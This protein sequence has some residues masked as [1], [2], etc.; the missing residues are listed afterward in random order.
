MPTPSQIMVASEKGKLE[1]LILNNPLLKKSIPTL[2]NKIGMTPFMYA[3]HK[4]EGLKAFPEEFITQEAFN[5]SKNGGETPLHFLA[6]NQ[7]QNIKDKWCTSENVTKVNSSNETPAH[8]AF[9]E[10]KI[11]WNLFTNES[12]KIKNSNNRT[13][14]QVYIYRHSLYRFLKNIPEDKLKHVTPEEILKIKS[15]I[16]KYSAQLTHITHKKWLQIFPEIQHLEEFKVAFF[17]EALNHTNPIK[18]KQLLEVAETLKKC[19]HIKETL[20]KNAKKLGKAF[21]SELN[22]FEH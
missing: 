21:T 6:L 2:K 18:I 17:Q 11:G 14:A 16:V 4:E 10:H 15:E 12:A 7:P 13:P 3:C 9:E 19:A 5:T 8:Y 22:H 1:G 20:D